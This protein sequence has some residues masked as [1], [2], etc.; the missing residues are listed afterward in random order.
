VDDG[1]F[2]LDPQAPQLVS[3]AGI[4]GVGKTT[5]AKNLAEILPGEVLFEPYNTNPF[6]PEVYAGRH[7]FALDSQLYFLVN[8]AK[9]LD[10]HAL[11][12]DKVFVT[13]YVFDKEMIYARRLLSP[14]QLALYE[15]LY[16]PIAQ[17]VAM[18]VLVI[19]LQ[20]T[21]AHCLQRIHGRNRPYEQGI[22]L[23][24]LEALDGDYRRLFEGWKACPVLR[25][26]ASR[27]TG[28]HAPVIEHLVLQI[29]AYLA[30]EVKKG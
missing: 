30:A 12:R 27:L 13:D 20:D 17:R 29:R 26:P 22:T 19:Y 23:E 25:V 10:P 7:E 1:N 11:A 4:I 16:E 15:A 14:V 8:R 18:P 5:L 21:P 9:Q 2:V 24:F 28:Y 3:V 6:L